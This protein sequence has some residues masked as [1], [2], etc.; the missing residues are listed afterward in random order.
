M[1]THYT[2]PALSYIAQIQKLK[3]RGLIIE[4]DEKAEH[5]LS[6]ISYY[7]LSGYWFPL[8]QDKKKHVFKPNA[9]FETAFN[10]YKFD[11]E[12]RQ[13]ILCELEKI[14]VAIRSQM[15]YSMSQVHGSFWFENS[16]LFNNYS[17]HSNTLSKI[18]S[19]ID[20][21]DEEFIKVFKSNY[22][23]K[24]P[25]SW[26]TLEITSFG[27]LSML[28]SNLKAP[29][30]KRQIANHFGLSEK[31]FQSWIH[32]IVYIRNVCA[33]HSRL[34]NKDMR[35]NPIVPITPKNC[36][37]STD[38]VPNDKVYF[39]LSMIVYLLN[40]INPNHSFLD[41]L[42]NLFL[43]YPNVDVNAMGFP[44]NWKSEELWK[45]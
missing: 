10:L 7:R 12:L 41:R 29:R 24:F 35:I 5:L 18:A 43:K 30:E 23:D 40:T 6:S 8:L 1:K 26:M 38:G 16:S 19:E 22:S 37:I 28:F 3:A 14:E 45:M 13:L 36:W 32:S 42:E 25:P 17:K 31:V 9:T 27:T 2:K 33:H 44:L 20:R 21:S 39:F 15:I 34:W 11:R 4:N